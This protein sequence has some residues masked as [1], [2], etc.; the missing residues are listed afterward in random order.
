M[1]R[2]YKRPE[3]EIEEVETDVIRTSADGEWD[4]LEA[5]GKGGL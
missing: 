3:I 2:I 1:K 5:I 4:D